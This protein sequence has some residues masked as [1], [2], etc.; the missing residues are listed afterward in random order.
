[1]P[2]KREEKRRWTDPVIL[3]PILSAIIAAVI[4]AIVG[5]YLLN[6]YKTNLPPS[7]PDGPASAPQIIQ[8][9]GQGKGNITVETD[10]RSY[11]IGEDIIISGN[12]GKPEFGKSVRIDMYKPD[13]GPLSGATS[14][15]TKPERDGSYRYHLYS[16]SY[17]GEDLVPGTYTVRVTYL[18][19]Y[20]ETKFDVVQ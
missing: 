4:T 15:L 10:K 20:T 1:L 9:S 17:A 13:G 6:Q 19:Q 7:L 8:P 18:K 2:K 3:A 16:F 5:P 12:V 14:L 11:V